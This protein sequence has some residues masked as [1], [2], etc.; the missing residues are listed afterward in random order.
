MTRNN[1]LQS[2]TVNPRKQQL[3]EFISTAPVIGQVCFSDLVGR[4][5]FYWLTISNRVS[6]SRQQQGNRRQT[7]LAIDNQVR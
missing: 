6:Q 5:T 1:G 3:V 4:E 7:L 2:L